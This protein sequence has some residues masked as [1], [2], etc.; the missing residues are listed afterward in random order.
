MRILSI[1]QLQVGFWQSEGDADS[2][3]RFGV[4]DEGEGEGGLADDES[5]TPVPHQIHGGKT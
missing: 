5:Q 1:T 3:F 2:Y 4:G